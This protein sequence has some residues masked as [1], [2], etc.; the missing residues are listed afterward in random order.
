LA[1]KIAEIS[2]IHVKQQLFFS[3]IALKNV[4]NRPVHLPGPDFPEQVSYS[5]IRVT[6]YITGYRGPLE[7]LFLPFDIAGQHR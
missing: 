2:N 7:N 5:R 1:L 4:N 6:T 3:P